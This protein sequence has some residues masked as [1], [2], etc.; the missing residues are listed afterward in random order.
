MVLNVRAQRILYL[1]I[2]FNLTIL[3]ITIHLPRHTEIKPQLSIL[4]RNVFY[5]ASCIVY[6]TCLF[7]GIII[8]C[9][10]MSK[11]QSIQSIHLVTEHLYTN[12]WCETKYKRFFPPLIK[13]SVQNMHTKLK[14][15][16]SNSI[17]KAT[18][19]AVKLQSTVIQQLSKVYSQVPETTILYKLCSNCRNETYWT[20]HNSWATFFH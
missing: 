14:I 8:S 18:V 12:A 4:N 16:S 5:N 19:L 2:F 7:G 20:G 3:S 13:F 9:P 6:K 15:I 1:Y 10:L 11:I 17:Y